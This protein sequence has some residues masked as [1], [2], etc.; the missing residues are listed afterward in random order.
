MSRRQRQP[1]HTVYGGAQLFKPDVGPRMGARALEAL[2]RFL[3]DPTAFA[4]C[5]G[6]PQALAQPVYERAVT[7]LEHEPVE[8]YRIDFEDGYGIRSDSEEDGHAVSTARAAAQGLAQPGFPPFFGIRIKPLTE[9]SRTRATKTLHLFLDTLAGE[10]GQPPK[11]F[12]VTLP[13]V[14][15]PRQ[16]TALIAELES[17]PGV[18]IELM[19]ETPQSIIDSA[20]RFA[21][22][23]LLDAAQGRCRGLHFGAYDYTACLG[24]AAEHQKLT[25]PACD[26]ARQAMLASTAGRGAMLSDGATNVLPIHQ[27]PTVVRNALRLHLDHIQRA[28]AHGFYQGWD[29]HPAQLPARY[30]AVYAF[31]LESFETSSARLRNFTEQSER[32]VRTGEI[33]D[34]AATG[35]GLRNFFQR[36]L[37][38]G[39]F[40]ASELEQAGL[41]IG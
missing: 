1:V 6:F 17:H 2:R 4:E 11:N 37:D 41:R 40:S 5:F 23:A 19:I 7:K 8:D 9:L 33:F 14:T 3:P 24:I 16:V 29:L 12:V 39:A 38:C 27:D 20:G 28:M 36:G 30:A 35:E 13:K 31:F 21:I 26:F 22:P 10:V 15:E 25:H 18:R 32:A 34:D